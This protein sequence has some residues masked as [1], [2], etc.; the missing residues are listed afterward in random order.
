MYGRRHAVL[1][2]I[3]VA[4]IAALVASFETRHLL[5]L[6]T[7]AQV[8][9][10]SVL[11]VAWPLRSERDGTLCARWKNPKPSA[12]GQLLLSRCSVLGGCETHHVGLTTAG[13]QL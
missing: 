2:T 12:Q 11:S 6:D 8:W 4:L 10:R 3:A 9:E 7:G 13:C 1:I 5:D